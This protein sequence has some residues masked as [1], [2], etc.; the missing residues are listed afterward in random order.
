MW[1]FSRQEPDPKTATVDLFPITPAGVSRDSQRGD[2]FFERKS[3]ESRKL[4]EKVGFPKELRWD[5]GK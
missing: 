1:P 4:L 5:V 3:E 2:P